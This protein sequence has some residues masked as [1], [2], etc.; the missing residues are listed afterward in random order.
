MLLVALVAASPV[1]PRPL[2]GRKRCSE[3]PLVTRLVAVVALLRLT[4]RSLPRGREL[5]AQ[6]A[7]P[8]LVQRRLL[9]VSVVALTVGRVEQPHRLSE[10]H[11]LREPEVAVL[12]ARHLPLVLLVVLWR[13]VTLAALVRLLRDAVHAAQRSLAVR[14]L[15]QPLRLRLMIALLLARLPRRGQLPQR[16][17]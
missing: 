13:L 4:G 3:H 14:L 6:Q 2:T 11:L 12:L 1:R 8:H 16:G 5:G 9:L 7:P 15:L 10:E 17:R